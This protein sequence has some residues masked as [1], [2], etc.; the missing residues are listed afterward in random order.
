MR[1]LAQ[2]GRA[3]AA[4]WLLRQRERQLADLD[5]EPET[6]TLRPAEAIDL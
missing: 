6:E 5:A 1:L 4:R 2:L 3:D